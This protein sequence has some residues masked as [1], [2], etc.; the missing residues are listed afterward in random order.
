[1]VSA[2]PPL[3][4]SKVDRLGEP[5]GSLLHT[6]RRP[7]AVVV[8]GRQTRR[9]TTL[10]F[11]IGQSSRILGRRHPRDPAPKH[12]TIQGLLRTRADCW[13]SNQIAGP[14]SDFVRR[15]GREQALRKRRH[16]S[17]RLFSLG[18]V[19]RNDACFKIDIFQGFEIRVQGSEI[20][21]KD[22][23]TKFQGFVWFFN[24]LRLFRPIDA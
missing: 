8:I 6:R 15:H 7:Q 3:V 9:G 18:S 13:T 23:L 11:S 1:M 10:D 22:S 17:S 2:F 16:R 14:A 4:R 21:T 24:S 5:S 20:R 19:R 12:G